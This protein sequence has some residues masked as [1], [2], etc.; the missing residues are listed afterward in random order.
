MVEPVAAGAI[1][2]GNPILFRHEGQLICHRVIEVSPDGL[3]T[4]GD[5]GGSAGKWI[6]EC[7]VLGKVVGVRRRSVWIGLKEALRGRFGAALVRLFPHLQRLR[8]YRFFVSPLVTPFLS[9]RIGVARG[10]R[11]HEWRELSRE[12]RV[13]VL[14]S[15]P[16]SHL[17]IAKHGERVAGWVRLEPEAAGWRP[18]EVYVR[19]RYRGLGLE[20]D[21][22]RWANIA[23]SQSNGEKLAAQMAGSGIR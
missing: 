21:L 3:L 4:R 12:D 16:R 20:S 14:P 1:R 10:T 17:V 19:L 9:Y 7:E 6:D 2:I 23:C 8:A 11:W 22:L 5:A 15:T 18:D 13:P